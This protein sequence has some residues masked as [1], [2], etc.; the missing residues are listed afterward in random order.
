MREKTT[1]PTKAGVPL[2]EQEREQRDDGARDEGDEGAQRGG[3]G[4]A[5][6]PGIEADLVA[7]H[8]IERALGRREERGH[9]GAGLVGREPAIPVDAL[10]DGAL[11]SLVLP[12]LALLEAVLRLEQLVLRTDRDVLADRH[13]EG[14]REQAR[15]ARD[16]DG[17]V[18]RGGACDAHHERQVRDE[19]VAAAE[20]RRSQE[21]RRPTLVR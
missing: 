14:A 17:L 18:V 6:G 19:A 11:P 2:E 3:P 20:D 7:E 10:E 13:R 9:D 12:Q 4:T 21:R 8:R 1:L 5:D 15:D 16:D